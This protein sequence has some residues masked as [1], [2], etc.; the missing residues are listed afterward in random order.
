M[1]KYEV[2][3][4]VNYDKYTHEE[5]EISFEEKRGKM[6]ILTD[7]V[8]SI[9]KNYYSIIKT[10]P[11]RINTY[12]KNIN[13]IKYYGYCDLEV[14]ETWN[15][16][17]K[18][19]ESLCLMIH[20]FRGHP[21]IWNDY[22]TKINK[23]QNIDIR[24]P[25]VPYKGNCSL[26]K[27]SLPIKNMVLNYIDEQIKVKQNTVIPI[28]IYGVSNGTRISLNIIADLI[29]EDLNK[30]LKDKNLK[31][32]IEIYCIAG[33]L[34]GTNNWKVMIANQYPL[35]NWLF[36]KIFKISQHILDDFR[37]KSH[38]SINLINRIRYLP[39]F[40]NIDI[41]YH[42][43]ASTEDKLVLPYFS[44]LPLLFKKESHHILHAES[45][46]SIVNALINHIV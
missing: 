4:E 29:N 34:Y 25:F 20:G 23:R 2:K 8:F 28:N 42:F 10:L 11:S 39:S 46:T 22:I 12:T 27:S 9:L 6:K 43:Y 35:I 24:V 40:S 38:A 45:H 21:S 41:N 37:Y 18:N 13:N 33:V 7:I 26:K 14:K 17:N 15:N 32:I 5:L 16:W 3:E 1:Y 19:S 30:K 31:I 44:S 36:T